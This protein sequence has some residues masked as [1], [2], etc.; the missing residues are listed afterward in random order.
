MRYDVLAND[1]TLWRVITG[2]WRDRCDAQPEA[3]SKDPER[4]KLL[5]LGLSPIVE[6]IIQGRNADLAIYDE[7]ATSLGLH[8]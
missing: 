5:L 8:K 3:A 7:N 2:K 4:D 6:K 1:L